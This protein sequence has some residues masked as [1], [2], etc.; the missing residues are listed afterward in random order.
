MSAGAERD[1]LTNASAEVQNVFL[2][3]ALEF[4]EKADALLSD[5]DASPEDRVFKSAALHDVAADFRRRYNDLVAADWAERTR[6]DR[7]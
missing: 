2:A 6:Q 1:A 7:L 5:Q 4:E 3:L